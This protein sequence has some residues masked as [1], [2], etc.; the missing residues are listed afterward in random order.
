MPER[1]LPLQAVL[2]ASFFCLMTVLTVLGFAVGAWMPPVATDHGSKVDIMIRYLL[3]TTG[4]IFVI[5]HGVL[6]WFVLRYG[7]DRGEETFRVGRRAETLWALIPVLVM[8]AVAEGGVL[9]IGLPVWAQVYG[10]S[11]RDA[12][13]VEVVGKQFEW[14]V[15]YPGK[16]GAFGRTDP[17]LVSDASNPLGLDERDP[18][19][20]DDIVVRGELRLPAGRPAVVRLRSHDVLHSFAVPLFRIKQDV[21]PGFTARTRFTARIPGRYEIACAELCGLGHYR[22][23]GF[24]VVQRP[25]EFEA[26]LREQVGWFE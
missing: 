15:R 10:E 24:A 26:W 13:D 2:L 9:L 1:K 25:E 4:V 6:T 19:A 5:G 7:R 11:P 14:L 12:L 8:T 17:A 23:R 16:D 18:A 21:I 20:K 22:M 3:I